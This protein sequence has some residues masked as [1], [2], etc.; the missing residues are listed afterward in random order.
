MAGKYMRRGDQRMAQIMFR[1]RVGLQGFTLAALLV[2]GYFYGEVKGARM[3][4][5]DMQLKKA[6]E[7]EA[8][9]IAELERVDAE[10]KA[11]EARAKQIREAIAAQKDGSDGPA[12]NKK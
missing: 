3:S 10:A 11:R 9:W 4:K 12:S 6:K 5:E 1:W 7:R 8:L 2:G